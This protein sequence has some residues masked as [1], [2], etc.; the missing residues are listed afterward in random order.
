LAKEEKWL[1]SRAALSA[2]QKESLIKAKA[3][4]RAGMVSHDDMKEMMGK[5][6]NEKAIAR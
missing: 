3:D 6:L 1:Q 5:K 4:L 2:Q